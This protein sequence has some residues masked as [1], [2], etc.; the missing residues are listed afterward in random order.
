MRV[1]VIVVSVCSLMAQVRVAVLPIK[2]LDGN[3]QLLTYSYAIADSLR[4]LLMRH[5]DHGTK[6]VVIPADTMEQAL[7]EFNLDPSSPQFESDLWRGI[8]K[9]NCQY[10]ITGSFEI[11]GGR[12]VLNLYAYDVATKLADQTNTARN[13]FKA[14]ENIFDVL[15]AAVR[16]LVPAL[17]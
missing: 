17:K 14:P 13:L 9:L 15:P 5:P 12:M 3:M 4:A 11:T 2:N 16:K 1:A 7:A 8:A 10:A 6:F